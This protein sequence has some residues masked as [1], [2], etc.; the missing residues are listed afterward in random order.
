M[1]SILRGIQFVCLVGYWTNDFPENLDLLIMISF[2]TSLVL[3]L[4]LNYRQIMEYIPMLIRCLITTRPNDLTSLLGVVMA[5]IT[6]QSSWWLLSKR[7]RSQTLLTCQVRLLS[8]VGKRIHGFET[9]KP[10][11]LIQTL[12]FFEFFD[13]KKNTLN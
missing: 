10:L 2:N 12:F 4:L 1:M 5:R 3:F 11:D 7:T 6:M 9:S 8:E 13:L